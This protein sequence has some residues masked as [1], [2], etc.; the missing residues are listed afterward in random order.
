MIEKQNVDKKTGRVTFL[1][2]DT[3]A[4][5]VNA[6]R[7]MIV[8]EVPTMAVEELE[9]VKNDSALYDE[10]L[11]HRVGLVPLST[12]LKSYEVKKP[13]DEYSAKNSLKLFMKVKGPCTVYAENLQSQDPKVKPVHPKTPIVKLMK[14]QELEFQALAV[15]GNGKKH[16]KFVPGRAWYTHKRKI[17][18]NNNHKEFA[19]FKDKF[20][21]Q[22]FSGGKLDAKLIEKHNLYEACAGVNDEIVKIE[23]DE[24]TFVFHIEPWG[25]LPPSEILEQAAD[26]LTLTLN[27]F[28]DTLK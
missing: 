16:T 12:D 7:R 15:L 27:E 2:K 20:P 4:A 22:A 3:N 21:T 19:K 5:F 6:L 18:V 1:I 14:G 24:K 28:A 23:N 13:E 10:M 17:T 26:K 11:A 25:Q 9:I 8:E